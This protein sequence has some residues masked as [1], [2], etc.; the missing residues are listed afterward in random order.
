MARANRVH[1]TQRRTASKRKAPSTKKSTPTPPAGPAPTLPAEPQDAPVYVPTDISPEDLFQAI[2][3]LRKE[4]Q[5]EID[6]LLSFLDEID[7]NI[8]DEAAGDE[9]DASYPD[10][11]S[12]LLNHP[13]EDDEPSLGSVTGPEVYSGKR[14]AAGQ[15]SWSQGISDDREGDECADDRE[16]DELQ[17]GGDEHDGAEREEDEP[18]LGWTVDGQ[19]T[20]ISGDFEQDVRPS[21]EMLQK[22]HDL[23]RR[24]PERGN[25]DGMHVE[26]ER[27][28][29][30]GKRLRNLSDRQH[31][32]VAPRVD[33][34]Q[35]TLDPA[36]VHR[37]ASAPQGDMLRGG[38]LS[39]PGGQAAFDAMMKR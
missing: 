31:K 12:H 11:R 36:P 27:G 15:E 32:I 2:G 26:S 17:H 6:R 16:G 35:V 28:F 8:D 39:Y 29:G 4:A 23:Y 3:K 14:K 37:E 18:S 34:G 21:D 20:G 38:Q 5:D 9:G 1:S 7:G 10:G 30:R 24:F 22:K 33:R 13:G 19:T 25:R